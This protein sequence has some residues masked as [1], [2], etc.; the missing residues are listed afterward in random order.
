VSLSLLFFVEATWIYDRCF[1]KAVTA[2]I[3]RKVILTYR[4]FRDRHPSPEGAI[5]RRQ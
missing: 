4:S 5:R 1:V 2:S 3:S